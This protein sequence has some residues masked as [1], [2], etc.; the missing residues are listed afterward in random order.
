M[1]KNDFQATWQETEVVSHDPTYR[2]NYGKIHYLQVLRRD[3]PLVM[4]PGNVYRLAVEFDPD[5]T[6]VES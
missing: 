3:H 5:L 1:I 2:T 4:R 6:M